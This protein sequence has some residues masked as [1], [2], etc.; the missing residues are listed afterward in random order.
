MNA[1]AAGLLGTVGGGLE[2]YHGILKENRAFAMEQ[3]KADAQYNRQVNLERAKTMMQDAG[4]DPTTGLMV[5][6]EQAAGM[7]ETQRAALRGPEEIA[8]DKEQR[9]YDQ[10]IKL[11]GMQSAAAM[12]R[13]QSANAQSAAN[14]ALSSQTQL[15]KAKLDDE[16]AAKRQVEAE[17]RAIK[18]NE[19]ATSKA[20]DKQM[21]DIEKTITKDLS[22][23]STQ[24][25]SGELDTITGN[26]KEDIEAY[27]LASIVGKLSDLESVNAAKANS[28]ISSS[29]TLKEAKQIDSSLQLAM[30]Q[31]DP[32]AFI[33]N[34]QS[35][36]KQE[37]TKL[38]NY[39]VAAGYLSYDEGTSIMGFGGN[40]GF[41]AYTYK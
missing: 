11:Q 27:K 8:M 18:R 13:Q 32:I 23:V 1:L 29:A 12:A 41:A 17:T 6:R 4:I 35:L 34:S 7:D 28:L 25:N 16:R 15:K 9:G 3:M 5:T 19:L 26:K 31:N 24:Y 2:E 10:A 37:K 39:G 36:S 38:L 22:K 40:E 30:Q 20:Q 21:S 33:T 14:A